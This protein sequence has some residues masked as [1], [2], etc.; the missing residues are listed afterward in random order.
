MDSGL[1]YSMEL[2]RGLS[3]LAVLILHYQHFYYLTPFSKASDLDRVGQPFWNSLKIVYLHGALGVQ[4]FWVVSGVVL[5][6]V[7]LKPGASQN[8]HGFFINRF[9]RIYP[10]HFLTLIFVFLL[11]Q[12]SSAITGSPQIYSNNSIQNFFL[13]LFLLVGFRADTEYG[14]NGVIWSVSVEIAL[15]VIFF[16][17][18]RLKKFRFLASIFMISF[19]AL[20]DRVFP[21]FQVLE[22][23]KYFFMGVLIFLIYDNRK[24]MLYFIVTASLPLTFIVPNQRTFLLVLFTVSTVLVTEP[25]LRAMPKFVTSFIR[26]LGGISYSMY[27]LHIPIQIG[28]LVIIQ[29]ANIDQKLIANDPK[30]FLSYILIIVFL[31]TF[32]HRLFEVP[33]RTA[34]RTRQSNAVG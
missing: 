25:F 28:I 31:S 24:V 22:C 7:Y 12:V 18:L 9:A 1:L 33:M 3:A 14:F 34:I 16:L 15:Y 2:L 23:G 19:F 30:F 6:V 32:V 11:Q 13:H 8:R 10:L 17:F 21:W 4:I 5:S 26:N 29:S 20:L 27:L